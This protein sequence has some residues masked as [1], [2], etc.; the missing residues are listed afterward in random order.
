MLNLLTLLLVSQPAPGNEL[1]TRQCFATPGA[2]GTAPVVMPPPLGLPVA[3]QKS[4]GAFLP[5]PLDAEVERQLR[6][7]R[8]WPDACQ[9]V[10]DGQKSYYETQLQFELKVQRK[11]VE[12]L[13]QPASENGWPDW[14]VGILSATGGVLIGIGAGLI[15]GYAVGVQR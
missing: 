3:V 6:C 2:L 14:L 9:A 4:D 7:G 11:L 1:I 15:V 10:L 5:K 13:A 12:Q 8:F